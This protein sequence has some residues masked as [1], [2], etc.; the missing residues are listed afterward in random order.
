MNLLEIKPTVV[1]KDL[2]SKIIFSAG[3]PK[4]GK[5]TLAS[6]FPRPLFAATEAGT[7]A[8]NGVYVQPIKKWADFRKFVKELGKKEVQDM[9]ETIVIDTVD[10]LWDLCEDYVLS[11]N[12]VTKV[13]DIPF[14]AG[15]G[16]IDKEFDR[17]VREIPMMG[18]GLVLISH[19]TQVTIT[20]ITGEE[21][22]QFQST[23]PKRAKPLV[24]RMADI[25]GHILPVV[26]EEGEQETRFFM[27]ETP[28]VQ[29]GSRFKYI[30]ESIVFTY[31][32]LINAISEAV[33]KQAEVDG[34]EATE[35]RENAYAQEKFDFNDLQQRI[36]NL[37]KKYNEEGKL[38]IF[39]DKMSDY[40]GFTDDKKTSPVKVSDLTEKHAE[41]MSI[42]LD[43]LE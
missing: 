10:I 3:A 19:S 37:G 42:F 16:M 27:R 6:K 21:T 12:G 40:F 43:D 25:S 32:N 39:T 41:A 20:S 13:G 8:L 9:F 7:N 2:R 5:T 31:E 4:T 35:T 34:V 28:L 36:I 22:N 29:A 30:P 1:S 18:Y 38:N 23:L 15:Y 24:N 11:A 17:K 33:E 26:N 14:G